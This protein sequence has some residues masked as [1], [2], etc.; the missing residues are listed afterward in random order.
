MKILSIVIPCY[1]SENYMEKCVESL[2]SGGEDVEI[3]IVNDGSKD[4]TA[5]I[6]DA[7]EKKYPGIVKAIH[8]ENGGHG[9]AVNAGI[10]NASGLFFKVVDSDDWVDAEAYPK[11]LDTLKELAGGPETVDMF[12][13]NF[14]YDKVGVKRKKVMRYRSEL[15][16]G[17]V[18]TWDEVHRLRIGHYLLM[19]SLIYRTKLLKECGLEL[20]KHTFYVDNLFAF[21]PFPYVKNM[22]YMDEIFYHYFI[23]RD[24]QSVNESVMI[25][26]I[27]QQIR[28]NKIMID[29]LAGRKVANKK[30]KKYMVS[31]LDIITTVSSIMLIRSGTEEALE[32]KKELWQYLKKADFSLYHKL[33][34]GIMGQTMNLPGKGGRQVSV[35]AYKI[36]QKFVGFN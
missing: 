3:L 19:H 9:E 14:I 28:V 20:P 10:R 1:N 32:K 25:G 29:T 26:R 15:P 4:R 17:R 6:A 13:S 23:G 33:R 30:L 16:Q 11:V 8:Q 31:Y 27:D 2:L 22:Y 7:Y 12:I 24:D 35:T 18:F 34:R 21:Q 36:A 5:E